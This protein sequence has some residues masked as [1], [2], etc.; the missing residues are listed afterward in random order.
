MLTPTKF[1]IEHLEI[2]PG[3]HQDRWPVLHSKTVRGYSAHSELF[4]F[5]AEKTLSTPYEI[6]RV[7]RA[8][9][10]REWIRHHFGI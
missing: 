5:M 8:R 2:I 3:R 7:R 6:V 10:L 1:C 9:T 4:K